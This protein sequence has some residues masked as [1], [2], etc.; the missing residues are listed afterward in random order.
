MCEE[1]RGGGI[2]VGM[3]VGHSRFCLVARQNSRLT[4]TPPEQCKSLAFDWCNVETISVLVLQICICYFV[5]LQ[6]CWLPNMKPH[7][8]GFGLRQR[9]QKLLGLL[10]FF[11]NQCVSMTNLHML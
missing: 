10:F 11:F 4:L 2:G 9:Q 8:T 3:K 7:E 5:L 6:S 1:A